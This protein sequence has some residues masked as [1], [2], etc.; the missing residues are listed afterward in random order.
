MN[1]KILNSAKKHGLTENEISYAMK[2]I[3]F[4]KRKNNADID[5]LVFM[6]IGLLENGTTCELTYSLNLMKNFYVVFH[7]M[8]PAR[9]SY[10][11][12]IKDQKQQKG[13]NN[14]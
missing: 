1:I 7:A 6:A 9:N 2:N 4:S 13:A 8:S 5:R 12:E 3:L 11:R 14:E 10:I